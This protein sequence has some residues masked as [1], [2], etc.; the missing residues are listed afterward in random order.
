MAVTVKSGRWHDPTVWDTGAV[1]GIGDS[2]LVQ[3]L[4]VAD[5]DVVVGD[6]SETALTLI[7]P[8]VCLG[9]LSV[10]GKIKG[11]GAECG[12]VFINEGR[13]V[14]YASG[15]IEIPPIS[16]EALRALWDTE[17]G[18][19][20]PQG[21][22]I[23][24]GGNITSEFYLSPNYHDLITP[25]LPQIKD[26]SGVLAATHDPTN[27]E[28]AIKVVLGVIDG[29]TLIPPST[30]MSTI[31]TLKGFEQAASDTTASL[32]INPTLPIPPTLITYAWMRETLGDRVLS[33]E[34][35]N[36]TIIVQIKGD[37]DPNI[38]VRLI[39]L[40]SN[41]VATRSPTRLEGMETNDLAL[42]IQIIR[43]S[44][45]RLEGMETIVFVPPSLSPHLSP[46]RLEGME[47]DKCHGLPDLP[48][49]SP[50]RLEGMETFSMIAKF[51]LLT[52]LRPALRGWKR[53]QFLLSFA[54]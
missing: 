22:I 13:W 28:N 43:L 45:T 40:A 50:T 37:I 38:T 54:K 24:I 17:F 19:E 10:I 23:P 29:S 3:H 32:T 26:L 7:K 12:L 35:T 47:T 39:T 53:N 21:L 31:N 36:N 48:R 44:P 14:L 49:L 15:G 5:E 11:E 33:V 25:L 52:S 34:E 18:T 30:L 8:L 27:P 46:T 2:A 6:G 1:P 42:V 20:M 4:I 16:Q 9:S 51:F 41:T